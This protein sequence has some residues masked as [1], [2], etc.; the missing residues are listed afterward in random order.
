MIL[1]FLT[2]QIPFG[3]CKQVVKSREITLEDSEHENLMTI[4]VT[5]EHSTT[6]RQYTLHREFE[7]MLIDPPSS[8]Q[9]IKS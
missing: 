7:S 3:K 8:L 2:K 1:T 4:R 9:A 5:I 6:Y